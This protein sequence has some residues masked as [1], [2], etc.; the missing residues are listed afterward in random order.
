MDIQEIDSSLLASL[1]AKAE[2]N[3]RKRI[4]FDLRTTPEDQ[5]QRML[6]CLEVGTEVPVHQHTDTSETIICLEG[7]LDVIV[8]EKSGDDVLPVEKSRIALCPAEGRYGVQLPVGAWHSVEVFE[9]STIFEAKDGA[10]K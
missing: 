8:Y 5:S 1:H 4:N 9:P 6:N 3:I 10:Y 7:R 2:D